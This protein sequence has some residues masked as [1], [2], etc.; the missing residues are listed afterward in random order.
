ME[1]GRPGDP[2]PATP[3]AWPPPTGTPSRSRTALEEVGAEH[4]LSARQGPGPGPRR[5]SPAARVGLPLFESIEVLGRE[6]SIDRIDAALA[7]LSAE[8]GRPPVEGAAVTVKNYS[9]SGCAAGLDRRACTTRFR[10][11]PAAAAAPRRHGGR[12][13]RVRGRKDQ[14]P[15][16]RRAALTLGAA[17]YCSRL[18][19]ALVAVTVAVTVVLA[20]AGPASAGV[21]QLTDGFEPG[22]N[23]ENRWSPTVVGTLLGALLHRAVSGRRAPGPASPTGGCLYR[24]G[25]V[26][27]SGDH[28]P[29]AVR[30]D[31]PGTHQV[32]RGRLGEAARPGVPAERRSDRSRHLDVHRAEDRAVSRLEGRLHPPHG[33]LDRA[34]RRRRPAV[35]PGGHGQRP[36][37]AEIELDDV[38]V[39]CTY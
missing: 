22:T 38:V 37:P 3:P 1:D 31:P 16:G 11:R 19:R 4:G 28:H 29:H 2:R 12:R 25:L 17:S 14:G 34:A 33:E 18:S 36:L 9:V 8:P 21:W 32:H 26:R 6:K 13:P 20:P 27:R 5:R 10:R 30:I 23:P 24:P 15:Q 39:Q 7:K 35:R